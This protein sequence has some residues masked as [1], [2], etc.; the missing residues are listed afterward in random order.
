MAAKCRGGGLLAGITWVQVAP[1]QLHVSLKLP[2]AKLKPPKS[3]TAASAAWVSAAR[4][5]AKRA[6]G[7]VAGLWWL[8]V[9]PSQ[10]QVSL[11][12]LLLA[13]KPPK[14]STWPVVGSVAIAARFRAG[15][16]APTFH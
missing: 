13:P 11:S 4:V 9:V 14:S 10:V 15:G 5:A 7:R 6:G 8:Q 1:S 3:T 2:V 12:A 16:L